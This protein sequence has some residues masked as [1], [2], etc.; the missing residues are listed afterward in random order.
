MTTTTHLL[1]GYETTLITRAEMTDDALKTLRD[2]MAAIVA[3]YGGE[4]V[5]QEDWGKRKLAYPIQKETRGQYTYIVYSG[6]P[7]IVHELER[8]LRIH[9]HVLRFLTV[10][11][12]EEFVP[13][14]FV[15]DRA[16][17][18]AIAKRRDEERELRREQRHAEHRGGRGGY[19]GGYGGGGYGGGDDYEGGGH[20]GRD[21]EW[22]GDRDS[23]RGGSE[24]S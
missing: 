13:E 11:L 12:A 16:N 1:P 10:N 19:G 4:V 17:N 14:Q 9:E 7:G 15:K 2:R 23:D 21:R 18:Q 6:K 8:N 24:H 5:M 3:T 20:R 22:G